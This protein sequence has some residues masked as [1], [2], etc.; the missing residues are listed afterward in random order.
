MEQDVIDRFEAIE[1]RLESLEGKN[2][3]QLTSTN[4]KKKSIKEFILEITPK[5]DVQNTLCIAYYLEKFENKDILT[6]GEIKKFF[7]D[8]KLKPPTN[9]PDKVQK[10]IGRGWIAKGD[11]RGEFYLTSSGEALIEAKFEGENNGRK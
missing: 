2:K 7:K 5:G 11:K 6:S 10:A 9:V 4:T 1:K 8:A 3:I